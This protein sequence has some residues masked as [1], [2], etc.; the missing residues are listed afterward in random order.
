M[1][2]YLL[3]ST[4]CLGVLFFYYKFFLEKENM[5]VFKRF[6]LLA[7]LILSFTIPL[8][9]FTVTAGLNEN[10]MVILPEKQLGIEENFYTLFLEKLPI[11]LG[12]IYGIGVLVFAFRFSKNLFQIIHKIK[13][14]PKQK[15]AQY[16]QVLLQDKVLPHT[17]FNYIFLNKTEFEAQEIPSEV[18]IHEQTHAKQKHSIDILI[19]ELIQVF[20][21][22]NPFIYF[23]KHSIKLNHEF[24]ADEA[25]LSQGIT[26]RHYQKLLLVFSSNTQTPYLANSI[27]YSLIKKR[28]TV[29]KTQTSKKSISIRVLLLM[30]L[31]TFLIYSFSTTEEISPLNN[32][33]L[34]TIELDLQEIATKA[35]VKEYNK[36]A[37][38]YNAMDEGKMRIKKA[39]VER[40][41]YLYN[42]MSDKQRK[43]AEPFPNFPPPPPKATELN[44]IMIKRV[45]SVVNEA[46]A[47]PKAP[48]PIEVKIGVND[49]DPN[50][51][52]PPPN[53]PK[54]VKLKK[55]KGEKKKVKMD[56]DKVKVQ[57][58]K[59]EE[60]QSER[61]AER[62][63][64]LEKRNEDRERVRVI[65]QQEL[66]DQRIA[67]RSNHKEREKKMKIM[68]QE[69]QKEHEARKKELKHKMKEKDDKNKDKQ[70]S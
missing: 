70:K 66:K 37:K 12:V 21:W 25:V 44:K 41:K 2:I 11:I 1:E 5:H 7:A 61:I 42:L 16:I 51:P 55:S 48:E 54:K 39:D 57:K 40:L 43:N 60:N 36:L 24:L 50:V 8:I 47:P 65:R 23:L 3:K 69:R 27:N 28:F 49:Q 6:Y 64:L 19:I 68:K 59:L 58:V 15:L 33:S 13:F 38:K 53:A 35:Q 30:P 10:T 26:P 31:L 4:A 14:N 32:N 34:D 45:P 67:L 20:F 63:V 62:K 29:M 22:F 17:F 52:P 56:K 18:L 46:P 9:T